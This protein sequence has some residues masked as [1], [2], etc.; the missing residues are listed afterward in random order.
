MKTI[1]QYIK[2]T[3]KS[4]GHHITQEIGTGRYEKTLFGKKEITETKKELKRTGSSDCKVDGSMLT[5]HLQE[6]V[7]KL[8][9]HGYRVISVTPVISGAYDVKSVGVHG[10]AGF[11]FSYTEGLIVVAESDQD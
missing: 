11:G 1:C 4:T 10:G 3:P 8:D 2:A 9:K 5:Q 6:L 7:D